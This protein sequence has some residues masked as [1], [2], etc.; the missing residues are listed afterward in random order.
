MG[1]R[2]VDR[3][4]WRNR[5]FTIFWAGQTLAE[6]GNTFSLIA[7]PLLVLK[8]TGSVVQMGLLTAVAAVSSIVTGVFGGILVDRLDRRRLMIVCDVARFLLYGLIPV[9][10]MIG[11]QI[12]LLYVVMACSGVFG[13][14]FRTSYVTAVGNLVDK[15]Q[16]VAANGR[17]QATNALAY[18]T[19]P[20]LAGLI[21][22]LFGTTA[23][24]AANSVT[25]G[26]SAI[27]LA[28]VRFRPVQGP[29]PAEARWYDVRQGFLAG[30]AF[31][32]RTPVL[33]WVTLL[34]MV[35]T[36][37]SLGM[38][39]VFIYH[40]R[41]GLGQSEEVVGYV[42]GIA[43]AGAVVGASLTAYLRRRLGFG[44]C[45]LGAY[46]LTGAAMAVFAMSDG[47]V[48]VT[49]MA[50]VYM[51]CLALAG[52][53]S[54]SLRQT[55]T[56]DHLLGRVTSAFWTLSEGLAPLGAVVLTALAGGIGVRR[57]L[58]WAAGAFLFV[59][60]AGLFTPIRQRSPE[61]ATDSSPDLQGLPVSGK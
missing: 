51:F 20:A 41:D 27:G 4:L 28:L 19:G 43:G 13:M 34:L 22:G 32:W 3:S 29:P 44:W 31:L 1:G 23:A 46:A 45:W 11:P 39:D 33:R 35:V 2:R 10:W 7:M 59:T 49:A 36:F 57:T 5:D 61:R 50:V 21:S 48:V 17:L 12:W 16:I 47:L 52:I 38:I 25:F 15:D 58:L 54:M 30:L 37:L 14:I 26:V 6:F 53:C 8:A 40:L 24:I 55:M 9:C 42:L 56:P 18:I 60:V